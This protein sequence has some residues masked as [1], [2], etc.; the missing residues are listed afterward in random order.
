MEEN[1]I[2]F[3]IEWTKV[4]I[5]HRVT[6]STEFKPADLEQSSWNFTWTVGSNK[7]YLLDAYVKIE[8]NFNVDLRKHR[9]NI[10]YVPK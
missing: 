4:Q 3:R 10:L 1:L 6:E 9:D 7:K 5:H 8:N 2:G